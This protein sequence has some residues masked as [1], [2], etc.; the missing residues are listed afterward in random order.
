MV[1]R[2][3]GRKAMPI[4]T[5]PRRT[6]PAPRT[7]ARGRA[8]RP[9]RC[10]T[11]RRREHEPDDHQRLDEG[12]IPPARRWR[13]SD[14]LRLTGVTRNRLRVPRS[15]SSSMHH[16]GPPASR[17][18]ASRRR[19]GRDSRRTPTEAGQL[20]TR[21]NSAPNRNS[22]MTGWISVMTRNAGCCTN[23]QP[24]QGHPPGLAQRGHDATSCVSARGTRGR[25]GGGRRRRATGARP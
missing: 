17:P 8:R 9:G 19:R 23:A 10:R 6:C 14:A 2:W 12:W 24:A 20:A 22:Q 13:G 11:G 7:P 3:R 15:I 25:C 21:P 16:A 5:A 1:S 18:R 4:V